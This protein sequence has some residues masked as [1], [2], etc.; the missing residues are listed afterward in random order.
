MKDPTTKSE[1]LAAMRAAR[2]EWDSWIAQV[3][4]KRLSEPVAPGEWSVKDILA[5]TTE[6]DRWLGLGLALKLQKPPDL[7]LADLTLE[8]FNAALHEQ[9]LHLD[10]DEVV[11]DSQRV[12]AEMVQAVAAH[13]EAYLFGTHRV[14]GVPYEVQPYELLKSESYGHYYDHLPTIKEWVKRQSSV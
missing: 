6:Y 1:L 3:P 11:A 12:F 14:A 8:Q 9:V 4:P 13:S 2:R 7:W 10:A 5:H